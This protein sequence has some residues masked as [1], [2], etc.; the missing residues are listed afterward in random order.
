MAAPHSRPPRRA[1][2][3]T[4][5]FQAPPPVRSATTHPY[6]W[7]AAR[8]YPGLLRAL[9]L[10]PQTVTEP[11][12]TSAVDAVAGVL[13]AHELIRLPAPEAGARM[14]ANLERA[15]E[16]GAPPRMPRFGGVYHQITEDTGGLVMRADEPNAPGATVLVVPCDAHA[17][18]RRQV[19][20]RLMAGASFARGGAA[21]AAR[22]PLQWTPAPRW[23]ACARYAWQLLGPIDTTLYRWLH[24][25]GTEPHSPAAIRDMCDTLVALHAASRACGRMR[26]AAQTS[27]IGLIRID[28]HHHHE[29]RYEARWLTVPPDTEVDRSSG[30]DRDLHLLRAALYRRTR[31]AVDD[32]LSAELVERVRRDDPTAVGRPLSSAKRAPSV[33]VRNA[34]ALCRALDRVIEARSASI[35]PARS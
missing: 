22:G 9:E 27:A 8:H 19:E 1:A 12:D 2:R 16:D 35:P 14:A 25:G 11:I 34:A 33:A 15:L 21:L 31:G 3:P 26:G 18:A 17:R 7:P 5:S 24:G 4:H 6:A 23:A 20:R 10:T 13:R 28:N 29:P 32:L 30:A